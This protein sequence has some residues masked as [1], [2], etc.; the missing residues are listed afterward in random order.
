MFVPPNRAIT[1]GKYLQKDP[2]YSPTQAIG[3]MHSKQRLNC[4]GL[5]KQKQFLI[6]KFFK[7]DM[8]INTNPKIKN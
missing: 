4:K 8:C 2:I 6:R 5:H 7:T 1:V 3:L